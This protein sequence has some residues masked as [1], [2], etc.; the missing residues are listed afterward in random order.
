M[1]IQGHSTILCLPLLTSGLLD[2]I[3]SMSNVSIG[4]VEEVCRL[5]KNLFVGENWTAYLTCDMKA[6]DN[7]HYAMEEDSEMYSGLEIAVHIDTCCLLT[8]P[9]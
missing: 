6:R 2:G 9:T 3:Q 7:R 4:E 8:W 1:G 5:L